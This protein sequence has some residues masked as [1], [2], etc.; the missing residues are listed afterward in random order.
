M[1]DSEVRGSP[2]GSPEAD[3]VTTDNLHSFARQVTQEVLEARRKVKYYIDDAVDKLKSDFRE[4]LNYVLREVDDICRREFTPR[5]TSR[6]SGRRNTF[7]ASYLEQSNR[8][9]YERREPA[10]ETQPPAVQQQPDLA[11]HQESIKSGD[12]PEIDS[13]IAKPSPGLAK[14]IEKAQSSPKRELPAADTSDNPPST[15]KKR[16]VEAAPPPERVS[17]LN[18]L[19]NPLDPKSVPED[20][21]PGVGTSLSLKD[22]DALLVKGRNKGGYKP[23]GLIK[24]DSL[25]FAF[26]DLAL[27]IAG[28]LKENFVISKYTRAYFRALC[29]RY[30]SDLEEFGLTSEDLKGPDITPDLKT[31]LSKV[32]QVL[33]NHYENKASSKGASK[34]NPKPK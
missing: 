6:R 28:H 32:K 5:N 17:T 16:K 21:S 10:V 19:E 29:A 8:R 9:P 2:P 4:G 23:S 15:L 3:L 33:D 13:R 30:K 26:A 27:L 14:S 12:L 1:S 20:D 24:K 31:F 7:R 18:T 22:T 11:V 34:P 25:D